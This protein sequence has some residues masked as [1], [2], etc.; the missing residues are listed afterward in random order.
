VGVLLGLRRPELSAILLREHL[1]QDSGEAEGRKGLRDR[2]RLVV[3]GHRDRKEPGTYAQVELLEAV[4]RE[5]AHDLAHPVAAVIEEQHSVAVL[6]HGH[7]PSIPVVH[8]RPDELV[9]LA[10]LVRRLDGQHRMLHRGAGP[11]RHRVVRQLGAVPAAVPIHAIVPPG[12][13]RH[14]HP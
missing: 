1:G 4:Q 8:Q 9:G 5:R 12:E 11:M 14:L 3:L 2:E 13:R 6:H 7:G 10:P